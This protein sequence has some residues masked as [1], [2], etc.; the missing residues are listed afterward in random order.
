MKIAKKNTKPIIAKATQ[1][2]T[3]IIENSKEHKTLL[4]SI[5][6]F[7][8]LVLDTVYIHKVEQYE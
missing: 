1:E 5:F 4:S 2:H 7:G 8:D 3:V 6:V